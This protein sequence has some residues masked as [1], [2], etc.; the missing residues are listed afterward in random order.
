MDGNEFLLDN[1]ENWER[2]R[3]LI[4]PACRTIRAS[5]LRK[6]RAFLDHGGH[7]IATT[8]LPQRSAEFGHDADVRRLAREMFGPG[9]K[10]RFLPNP[11]ESTL[12]KVL[13]EPGIA[14]DVRIDNATDIPRKM[15]RARGY[16]G[17]VKQ[18]P[19]W[20]EGGNREF[21]YIHRS[22]GAAEIYFFS[23]ASDLDVTADVRLRGHLSLETWDPHTGD[24]Q[25]LDSTMAETNGQPTTGFK[26][27]LPPIRSVFVVGR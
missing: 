11:D 3:V 12:Q 24:I 21:A 16:G 17:K 23:N 9:G 15:R 1:S 26:L 18:D 19:D 6:I 13:D 8:C 25:P 20:Y 10:G 2:Y 7:V 5:N 27:A 14:W 22:T 4:L